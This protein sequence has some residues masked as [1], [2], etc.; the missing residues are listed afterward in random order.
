MTNK[1]REILEYIKNEGFVT[2][3]NIAKVFSIGGSMTHRHLKNLLEQGLITKQGI[4]P[5]V[6]YSAPINTGSPD[7]IFQVS[8]KDVDIIEKNFTL[9]EP[10]GTEITGMNGFIKWCTDRK[11]E[12]EDKAKEYVS[13]LRDYSQFKK[14]GVIDATQKL[15]DTFK[16]DKLFLDKLY[17]LH[18][19]SLPVFGRTKIGQW[20]FH[21][22]QSQNKILMNKVLEIIVPEIKTFIENEKP[23]SIAFVPPTIKRIPQFMKE[24]EKF[25]KINLPMIKIEKIQTTIPVQQK[26]LKDIKDRIINANS[27][28]VIQNKNIH[29]KKVLLIDDFTGSG[30]TLNIIA[31]KMKE[32][33]IAENVIGLTITGSMDGFEIVKEV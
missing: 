18:S 24:L 2:A 4:P 15:Y 19:Y 20:L 5:K 28:M 32:Q 13:L 8:N 21:A 22:K 29:Y 11:L 23:D 3:H 10:D 9:L 1:Q 14:S 6:F 26:S 25:L 33:Y 17:Y 27:T 7:P 16:D 30:A 12:V 31:K